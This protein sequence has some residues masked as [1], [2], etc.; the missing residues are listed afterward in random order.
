MPTDPPFLLN[1]S[2]YLRNSQLQMQPRSRLPRK[3][4]EPK[5]YHPLLRILTLTA[6]SNHD[7]SASPTK[8]K[9]LVI[10][11]SRIMTSIPQQ[12][13]TPFVLFLT[14]TRHLLA[15]RSSNS[16]IN[17]SE[18]CPYFDEEGRRVDDYYDI[19]NFEVDIGERLGPRPRYAVDLSKE[20]VAILVG[21]GE[22]WCVEEVLSPRPVGLQEDMLSGNE[23]DEGLGVNLDILI[24]WESELASGKSMEDN[25]GNWDIK[26][27]K[28]LMVLSGKS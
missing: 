5:I 22:M 8:R 16:Y 18:T 4:K 20:E 3:P 9:V 7:Y 13:L 28:D 6:A 17:P 10:L 12:A 21:S 15:L 24:A 2:R 14:L 1:L 26:S 19:E 11:L 23:S 25:T 27:L